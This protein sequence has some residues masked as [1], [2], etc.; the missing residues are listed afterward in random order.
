MSDR[1]RFTRVAQIF[2]ELRELSEPERSQRLDE[3]TGSND[4]L[5]REVEKLLRLHESGEGL[6]EGDA[7]AVAPEVMAAA[8]EAEDEAARNQR[9]ARPL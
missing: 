2:E 8:V 6:L 1:E 3:A 9:H 7:S 5:R 4:D